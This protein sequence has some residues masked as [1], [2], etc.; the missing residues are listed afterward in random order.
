MLL[1]KKS[2]G[3]MRTGNLWKLVETGGNSLL[4]IN[5]KKHE[6]KKH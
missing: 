3:G 6:N 2:W 1:I 5:I 4:N